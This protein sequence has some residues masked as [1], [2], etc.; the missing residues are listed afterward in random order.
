MCNREPQL[1]E[2]LDHLR[3]LERLEA[4]R[5]FKVDP[6]RIHLDQAAWRHR[7]QFRGRITGENDRGHP[8][9]SG[10]CIDIRGQGIRDTDDAFG[11]GVSMSRA[12]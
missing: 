8:A 12:R 3:A 1:G 5:I 4:F 2:G 11:Y 9:L 6:A 10:L 7:L